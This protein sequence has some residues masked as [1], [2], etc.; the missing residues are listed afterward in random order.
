LQ[1]KLD[2][3]LDLIHLGHEGSLQSNQ[4]HQEAHDIA[5]QLQLSE[6]NKI[7]HKQLKRI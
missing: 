3:E 7:F 2:T 6:C 1:E 4:K 5:E